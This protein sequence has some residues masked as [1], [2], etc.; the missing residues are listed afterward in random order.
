MK[1]ADATNFLDNDFT[2]GKLAVNGNNQNT[3]VRVISNDFANSHV[4]LRQLA[5]VTSPALRGI[6]FNHND[7]N[8]TGSATIYNPLKIYQCYQG[9]VGDNNFT[10]LTSHTPTTNTGAAGLYIDGMV[11]GQ[12]T[13]NNIDRFSRGMYLANNFGVTQ[14]QCNVF[15][16][17]YEGIYLNN[18][19][20]A[21]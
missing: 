2:G 10:N 11:D 19:F 5:G 20:I 13:L 8:Y 1:F 3:Q 7:M 16:Y 4:E 12:V 14:F 15:D 17:N 9:V 6:I 21:N 18:A